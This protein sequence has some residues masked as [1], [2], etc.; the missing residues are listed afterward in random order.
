MVRKK[1]HKKDLFI[2]LSVALIIVFF[3]TFYIW[4]LIESTR[5]GYKL[6]TLETELISLQEKVEKLETKKSALLSL[7]R[8]EKIAKE[9]L[10]LVEPK[11]K[12]IYYIKF[13][14]YP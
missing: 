4:H 6:N 10:E 9:K 14:P 7:K 1:I 3:L 2:G 5:I 11:D 12:Q 13:I 8:V